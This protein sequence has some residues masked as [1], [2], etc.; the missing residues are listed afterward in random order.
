MRFESA[1]IP[2]GGYWSTPFCKWQG[3]LSTVHAISLAAQAA[4]KALAERDIPAAEFDARRARDDRP[5][6]ARRCMADPGS[7]R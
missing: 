2:Y 6:E 3:S 7:P 5:A 4:R 1:F